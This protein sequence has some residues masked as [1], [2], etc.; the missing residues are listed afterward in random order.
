MKFLLA[1]ALTLLL[2]APGLS[3]AES[4]AVVGC[5]VEVRFGSYAM[6][7]DS[8]AFARTKAYLARRPR[9]IAGVIETPWGRE[10][11]RTLCIDTRSRKA[12][13]QVF[14]DL[15]RIIGPGRRGPT[16]LRAADGRR[17]RAS[18]GPPR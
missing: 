10:G 6:G 12:T 15:R 14:A 4:P 9:L 7:I 17:Y 16:D 5:D 18:P 2:L 1:T 11:E 3:R 8:G 13:G